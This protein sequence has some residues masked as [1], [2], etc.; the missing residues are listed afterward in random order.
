MHRTCIKYFGRQHRCKLST[1][2]A[3]L[4]CERKK[5][6]VMN[7]DLMRQFGHSLSTTP[8]EWERKHTIDQLQMM[9]NGGEGTFTVKD[10][11]D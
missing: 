6:D 4:K 2:A 8:L 7:F 9:F 1:R 11:D 5:Y 10:N 3:A